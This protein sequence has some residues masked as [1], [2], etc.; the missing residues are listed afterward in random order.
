MEEVDLLQAVID[1]SGCLTESP[2]SPEELLTP[3]MSPLLADPDCG[4]D[5]PSGEAVG[6][7]GP[8]EDWDMEKVPDFDPSIFIHK[9][10]DNS[11]ITS[12]SQ[13]SLGSPLSIP[14]ESDCQTSPGD[15]V[16]TSTSAGVKIRG[17]RNLFE[18]F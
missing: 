1:K 16:L 10:E 13:I 17:N 18:D 7:A 9:V 15:P 11:E 14:R 4:A 3:A 2:N 8:M 6:H 12:T 5:H